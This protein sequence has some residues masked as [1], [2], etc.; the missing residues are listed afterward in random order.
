VKIY[1]IAC[2]GDVDARLTDGSE[3][4]QHRPDLYDLPFW[5]CDKCGGFVGC[6]HKTKNRTAP[7]GNIPTNEIRQA[8]KR[9]HAVLDP[10]WQSG[11]ITRKALYSQLTEVLGRQYHTAELRSI[12]ECNLIESALIKKG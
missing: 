10:L 9:I 12:A 11:S 7:L 6:H 8:R 2:N 3:I 1:C 4:Y 5:K